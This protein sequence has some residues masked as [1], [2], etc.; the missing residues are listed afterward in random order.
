MKDRRK[1]RAVERLEAIERG[2]VEPSRALLLKMAQK[3][4]RPLLLF[5]LASPPKSGDRG[6]DFRSVPDRQ[7][8]TE[9]LIDALVRDVRARQA[10]VRD[11]L[12]D[13][14]AHQILPFVGSMRMADGIDAVAK[15]I[16]D[17]IR[18]DLTEY[19]A[20]ASPAGAF[21]FLRDRAETA[22]IFVLLIGNLGSHHT[23]ISVEAFRGFALA[24]DAAP[25]VV[26][27]DQDAPAA[28]S[29]TLLHELAHLWLGRT[30]ISGR[31]PDVEIEKFCNDVAAAL[32]L[33]AEELESIGVESDMSA[34]YAMTK[35][36]PFAAKRNLSGSMVAYRLY[37]ASKM[38][39]RSWRT[40][41]AAYLAQW[42][43][44]K[45]AK[46]EQQNDAGGPDYYVVRR[47]RLG[48]ALLRLVARSVADGAL[49]PTRAS[50]VP[51][52]RPNCGVTS[53]LFSVTRFTSIAS[54]SRQV[55]STPQCRPTSPFSCL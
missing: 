36:S 39:E 26:I 54:A 32:L 28:W 1:Q 16:R 19:R 15:S 34:D 33:P 14:E 9:G 43:R 52:S 30:G 44:S 38:N 40:V 8:D 27:N 10:T 50:Q 17:V 29:F 46:R 51:P 2:K 49:T 35:I 45:Q 24:D 21:A 48:Q 12:L 13:D 6:D 7:T 3:Y 5:Y 22:G 37:R 53:L 18:M 20:Q 47:H 55:C 25:F 42:R 31:R 41:A 11:V 4:R 23:A